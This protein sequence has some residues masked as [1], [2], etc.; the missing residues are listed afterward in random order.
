[1][2]DFQLYTHTIKSNGFSWMNTDAYLFDID[3]TLLISRDG[4]HRN[5]LHRAMREAYGVDTT[6]D[7]IAYHGKTDLG[8]LRAA[9]ARVGVSADQFETNLPAA[10]A[11]VCRDV[12]ANASRI[13]PTVCPAIPQVLAE[14]RTAGKLLGVASGNLESVGWLKLETA[15]LREFFSFGCFSDHHESRSDIFREGAAQVQ[16]RMGRT[17]QV[18]FIG[19]TPEDIKAARFANSKIVAVCTGIFT[20]DDLAS[21]EPDACIATCEELLTKIEK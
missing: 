8:I 4:V 1:M 17:A 19:D 9:L 16:R 18:C 2:N 14:L 5:A 12:S 20:A 7:G 15:G 21:Y 11:A 3:G 13:T 6:I 10:I